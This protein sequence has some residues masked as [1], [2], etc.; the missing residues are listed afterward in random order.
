MNLCRIPSGSLKTSGGEGFDDIISPSFQRVLPQP[1]RK[2]APCPSPQ[3]L[4]MVDVASSK[5]FSK[6]FLGPLHTE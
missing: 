1:G 4:L 5:A 3:S 2:F 6:Y